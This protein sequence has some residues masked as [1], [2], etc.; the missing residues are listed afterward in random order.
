MQAAGKAAAALRRLCAL[1]GR[2]MSGSMDG[3]VDLYGRVLAEGAVAGG[4]R[5]S[6]LRVYEEDVLLVMGVTAKQ[7]RSLLVLAAGF[8]FE[9]VADQPMSM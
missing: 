3:L 6:D 5:V 2:Y 9:F 8:G 4:Q 7:H 1:C